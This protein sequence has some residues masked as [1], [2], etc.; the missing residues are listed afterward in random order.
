MKHL[1]TVVKESK[2]LG[3]LEKS[4][5]DLYIKHLVRAQL[6]RCWT[7][8]LVL[9]EIMQVQKHLEANLTA[10]N[11]SQTGKDRL[12]SK[13][14]AVPALLQ[15][16]LNGQDPWVPQPG[17]LPNS[18]LHHL[19]DQLSVPFLESVQESSFQ[20]KN[21]SSLFCRLLHCTV[22]LLKDISQKEPKNVSST[23]FHRSPGPPLAM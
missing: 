10:K 23:T 18:F 15:R 11:V 6:F 22:N 20:D 21:R 2:A 7:G 17:Q 8:Q 4:I 5:F 16:M 9:K 13:G 1:G 19:P 14:K 12:S 3:Y